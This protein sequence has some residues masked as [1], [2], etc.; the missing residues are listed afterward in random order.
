MLIGAGHEEAHLPRRGTEASYAL[1]GVSQDL[2]VL[3]SALRL[4]QNSE[5][6]C[7]VN[8]GWDIKL[9]GPMGDR[10]LGSF[11]GGLG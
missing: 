9:G 5:T 1:G 8:D 4:T 6:A 2:L 7:K 3:Q 11:F 10:K